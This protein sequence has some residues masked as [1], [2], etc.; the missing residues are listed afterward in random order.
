M[1]CRGRACHIHQPDRTTL[2]L[3]CRGRAGMQSVVEGNGLLWGNFSV[4]SCYATSGAA[5]VLCACACACVCAGAC[6]CR[7]R[8]CNNYT[9]W[10]HTTKSDRPAASAPPPP[11]ASGS[12]VAR[13]PTPCSHGHQRT[14]HPQGPTGLQRRRPH[15][16]PPRQARSAAPVAARPQQARAWPQS[17]LGPQH[18]VC[19]VTQ[20]VCVC[21]VCVRMC[22]HACV[23]CAWEAGVAAL[24]AGAGV[25][26]ACG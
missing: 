4:D 21:F 12:T 3:L 24:L 2:Q 19:C 13:T 14:P 25:L 15:P 20:L 22:M 16:P 18:Q 17:L 7:V 10:S 9:V 1:C 26:R 11:S 8:T 5:P 23:L 6:A